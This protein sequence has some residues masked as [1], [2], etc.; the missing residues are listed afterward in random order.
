MANGLVVTCLP[1]AVIS[2]ISQFLDPSDALFLAHSSSYLYSVVTRDG[3]L[4][5]KHCGRVWRCEQLTDGDGAKSWYECWLYF[6]KEFGRYRSCY[7]QIKSAWKKIE[8]VF[9]EKC[10]QPFDELM[11]SAAVSEKE[12][13]EMERKLGVQLPCDYRC[14]LRLHGKRSVPLGCLALPSCD[15]QYDKQRTFRLLGVGD[16]RV[17]AICPGSILKKRN[18]HVNFLTIAENHF[19]YKRS[20]SEDERKEFL[21]MV[22]DDLGAVCAGCPEGH[23]VIGFCA[24]VSTCGNYSN[25]KWFRMP[26][27]TTFAGWLSTEAE[28]LQHYHI[29]YQLRQLTRLTLTPNCDTVTGHF[30][31]RIATA[32]LHDLVS[33]SYFARVALCIIVELSQDSCSEG[34]QLVENCLFLDGHKW[35]LSSLQ[36]HP[37]PILHPGQV[38]EYTGI[39]ELSVMVGVLSGHIVMQDVESKRDT[40]VNLPTVILETFLPASFN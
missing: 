24:T 1:A 10:Q 4:W 3:P 38:V 6:C 32:F 28:R 34:Y 40:Q 35:F 37:P 30:T 18:I 22:I 29:S 33:Q 26:K 15:P 23:V 9:Q 19:I 16:V 12:L 31:L 14:S 8:F 27:T 11:T 17:E 7:A 36:A 21:F 20:H 13:D 5:K 39:L 2:Q 25:L